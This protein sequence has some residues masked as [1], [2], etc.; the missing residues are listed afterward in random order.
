MHFNPKI[1]KFEIHPDNIKDTN[2]MKIIYTSLYKCNS[3]A[4]L[5]SFISNVFSKNYIEIKHILHSFFGIFGFC[6]NLIEE[7]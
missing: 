2:Q 5:M 3:N 1:E 6:S 7:R 4:R